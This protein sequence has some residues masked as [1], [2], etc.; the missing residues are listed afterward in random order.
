[1]PQ[2]YV[3]YTAPGTDPKAVTAARRAVK[4]MGCT[5]VSVAAGTMLVEAPPAEVKQVAKALPGWRY[6]VEKKTAH[7]PERTPLQRLRLRVA[8]GKG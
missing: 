5:V 2:R 8:T 4:A 3:F 7:L 1:M 6:S